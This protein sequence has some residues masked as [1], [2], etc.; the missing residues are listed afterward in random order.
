[1]K[2]KT[3]LL[4]AHTLAQHG[5]SPRKAPTDFEFWKTTASEIALGRLY[6]VS[7]KTLHGSAGTTPFI[8]KFV[9]NKD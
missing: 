8:Q 9:K 4:Y 3:R 2:L 1:M 6:R 5:D 7:I